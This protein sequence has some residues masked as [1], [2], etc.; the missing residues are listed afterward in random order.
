MA[1]A[2]F[3]AEVRRRADARPRAESLPR[4]R[5]AI[6]ILAHI[7]MATRREA[8]GRKLAAMVPPGDFGIEDAR[9]ISFS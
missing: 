8:T 3:S 2:D 7:A 9:A 4:A 1:S 5:P 6:A